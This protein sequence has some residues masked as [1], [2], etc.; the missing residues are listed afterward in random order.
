[1]HASWTDACIPRLAPDGSSG[2]AK[3]AHS[4]FHGC[5]LREAR[6]SGS[7]RTPPHPCTVNAAHHLHTRPPDARLEYQGS[8]V[9]TYS[10]LDLAEFRARAQG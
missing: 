4:C 7:D 9:N 2:R 10:S 3:T 6:P 8:L 1:M 5:T